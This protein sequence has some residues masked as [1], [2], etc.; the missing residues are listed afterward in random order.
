M[1]AVSREP[2]GFGRTALP[3]SEPGRLEHKR[4]GRPRPGD[5]LVQRRDDAGTP[6]VE[7]IVGRRQVTGQGRRARMRRTCSSSAQVMVTEHDQV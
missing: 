4:L 3:R 2:A 1:L 6:A 5:E 7:V